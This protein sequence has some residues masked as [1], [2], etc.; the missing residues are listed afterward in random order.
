[1]NFRKHP[2]A[3]M[4]VAVAIFAAI[5]IPSMIWVQ[6]GTAEEQATKAE[7]TVIVLELTTETAEDPQEEKPLPY[8]ENI[9]LDVQ[10]QEYIVKTSNRYGIDPAIVMAIIDRESDY[11]PHTIGDK[12]NSFGLCQIQPRWHTERMN[13]LG[14]TDLLNPYHNVTVCVD[15]LA[16]LADRYDGDMAKALVGYN[17]GYY[18]G[19]VTAYAKAVLD[20]AE[21]IGELAK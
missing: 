11:N 8:W 15:Y 18:K 1:M 17:Q 9:P 19:T 2:M 21:R 16:E 14:C 10:L 6:A 3:Q 13:K 5:I 7:E 20:N 12:G 4:V